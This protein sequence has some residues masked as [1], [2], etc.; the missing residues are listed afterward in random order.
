GET[1]NDEV[2]KESPWKNCC[3]GGR[4]K[5]HNNSSLRQERDIYRNMT[6][7]RLQLRRSGIFI[8]LLKELKDFISSLV[9][10]HCAPTGLRV[11]YVPVARSES[12][13]TRPQS[14]MMFQ[15]DCANQNIALALHNALFLVRIL[16]HF[17]F[18]RG[19]LTEKVAHCPRFRCVLNLTEIAIVH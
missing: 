2:R 4:G 12:D 19:V 13:M 18:W 15:V 11:N 1:N 16:R 10:K 8:S 6:I 14:L 7:F 3:R 5:S 17:R 9:H